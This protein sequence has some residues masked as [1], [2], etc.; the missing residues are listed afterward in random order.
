MVRQPPEPPAEAL[1]AFPDAS[2]L[3]SL[4]EPFPHQLVRNR[5]GKVLGYVVDS[6]SAN[7]TAT[8]YAG[9]VPV[10]VYLDPAA[11]PG[12]IYVL[13]NRETPAYL[14]II[15]SD[16]LLERLLKYEPARPES[17]DA[18]TLATSSSRAVI[19]GVTATARRVLAEIV[20]R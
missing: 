4:R 16:G 15:V 2:V 17:I 20:Q 5:A 14:E 18:V 12:R 1:K 10:R 13:D 9:P 3:Q 19:A 7:T 11:R 6:D 8:G